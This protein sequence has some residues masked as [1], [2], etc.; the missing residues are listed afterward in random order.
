MLKMGLLLED[1]YG[2]F[3]ENFGWDVFFLFVFLI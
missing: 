3:G 2:W 1:C